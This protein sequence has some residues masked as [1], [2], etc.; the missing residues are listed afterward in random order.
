MT[1]LEVLDQRGLDRLPAEARARER[2]RGGRV[3]ANEG[4]LR[5]SLADVRSLTAQAGRVPSG[6]GGPVS[7]AA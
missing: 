5:E 2:A 3:G 4:A 7:H 1:L 6:S